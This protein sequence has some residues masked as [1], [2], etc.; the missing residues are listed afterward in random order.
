MQ[1]IIYYDSI[2]LLKVKNNYVD[3]YYKDLSFNIYNF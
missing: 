3:I 1:I 2:F